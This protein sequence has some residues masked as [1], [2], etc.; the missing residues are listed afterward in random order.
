MTALPKHTFAL[1]HYYDRGAFSEIAIWFAPSSYYSVIWRYYFST[2]MV[3]ENVP[4]QFQH[5]L[6]FRV[7]LDLPENYRSSILLL[8]QT[9]VEKENYH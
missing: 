1:T 7:L 6:I 2:T 4:L 3:L 5:F 8:E 9:S